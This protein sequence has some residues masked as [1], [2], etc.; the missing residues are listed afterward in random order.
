MPGW[1]QNMIDAIED[2]FLT[3]ITSFVRW[4]LELTH[5]FFTHSIIKTFFEEELQDWKRKF[6]QR[7]STKKVGPIKI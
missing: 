6:F 3:T 2:W 4:N 5:N 1:I 7:S